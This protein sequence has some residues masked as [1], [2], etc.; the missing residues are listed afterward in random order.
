[1]EVEIV[2]M[3]DSIILLGSFGFWMGESFGML[4]GGVFVIFFFSLLNDFG[5]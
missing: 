1:M 3:D 2:N 4:L 5:F